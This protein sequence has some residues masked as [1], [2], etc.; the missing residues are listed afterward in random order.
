MPTNK[1]AYY[2]FSKTP[3]SGQVAQAQWSETDWIRI[4]SVVTGPNM[5]ITVNYA[6]QDLLDTDVTS[7]SQN[8]VDA[9]DETLVVE[10]LSRL[11]GQKELADLAND[12]TLGKYRYRF[13]KRMPNAVA[14]AGDVPLVIYGICQFGGPQNQGGGVGDFA[15]DSYSLA[16]DTQRHYRQAPVTG[17]APTIVTEAA[18]TGTPTV[19]ETLT[20]GSYVFDCADPFRKVTFQWNDDG[21]PISGATES[22]YTLTASETGGAITVDVTCTIVDGDGEETWGSV[23]STSAATAAVSA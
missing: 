12:K 11:T 8:T 18:I 17:A 23:T 7:K 4:E 21:N 6:S 20:A 15:N 9:G 2:F 22:T 16:F 13:C 14:D 1:D 19:G 3:Q 10:Y 5:G